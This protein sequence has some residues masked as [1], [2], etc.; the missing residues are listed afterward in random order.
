MKKFFPVKIIETRWTTVAIEGESMREVREKC[1]AD[2]NVFLSQC[3]ESSVLVVSTGTSGTFE[4]KSEYDCYDRQLRR[5]TEEDVFQS[6]Q[7][8][9]LYFHEHVAGWKDCIFCA[10]N[11]NKRECRSAPCC[12]SQRVDDRSGYFSKE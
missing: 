1:E 7:F 9:E 4:E 8:G 2:P 5:V 6:E 11:S 10:L 12:R 3:S